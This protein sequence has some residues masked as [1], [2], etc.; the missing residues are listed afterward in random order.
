M[1][2]I[3]EL[4]SEAVQQC[5][6]TACARLIH[7]SQGHA[8]LAGKAARGPKDFLMPLCRHEIAYVDDVGLRFGNGIR[9]ESGALGCSLHGISRR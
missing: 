8:S 4:R 5:V 1:H 2:E 6:E 3:S 7:A 9:H